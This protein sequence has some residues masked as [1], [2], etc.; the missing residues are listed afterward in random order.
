M[1]GSNPVIVLPR[2]TICDLGA[3]RSYSL[4]ETFTHVISIWGASADGHGP[5]EIKS[6]FPASRFH[7]ARFDDIVF[8][9]ASA[10]TKEMVRS[11]LDFG[12]GLHVTDKVLVHCMAGVSRSSSV[13]YA[14]ACQYAVP[15]NET[16]VLQKLVAQSPWIKPNRRVVNFSDDILRRG[17]RMSAA[18]DMLSAQFL[19]RWSGS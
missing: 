14:L 3:V 7:A 16:A 15:G 2:F 10:V 8:E 11:I 17:G 12:S 9:S 4:N 6:F 19:A 1:K 5:A 13:A 18:I